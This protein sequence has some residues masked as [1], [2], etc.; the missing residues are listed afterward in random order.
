MEKDKPR[1]NG[2]MASDS[3]DFHFFGWFLHEKKAAIQ[4]EFL[5]NEKLRLSSENIS[6]RTINHWQKIGLIE[7]SREDGKGWRKYSISDIIWV[8]VIS[9]L[10]CFGL[11]I[12]LIRNV[13]KQIESIKDSEH[14]I[15]KRTLFDY[16]LLYAMTHKK[17][18]Y[19]LVFK[20]GECL[21]FNTTELEFA[22]SF[23]SIEGSYIK[24]DLY[25]LLR[26]VY[27]KESPFEE[28]YF[29]P[30]PLDPEEAEVLKT[31]SQ[32][33]L[34]SMKINL[35]D[36]AVISFEGVIEEPTGTRIIDLL[37]A[38][39]FQSVTIKRHK[40]KTTQIERTIKTK[41]NKRD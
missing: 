36:G 31:I 25:A 18:A 19:L 9:E 39:K 10:R 4:K 6:Y 30:N 12:E 32:K 20:N 22:Q 15:S 28:G 3:F 23:Q 8:N 37:Q 2:K 17:P 16:Y 11:S 41:P 13:K 14:K 29:T 35:K 38:N 26:K 24:I 40:G 34:K 5:S 1:V 33:G 21:L 7:D 27:K